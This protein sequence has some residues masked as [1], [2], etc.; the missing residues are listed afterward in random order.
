MPMHISRIQIL[1]VCKRQREGVEVFLVQQ[2]ELCAGRLLSQTSYLCERR[3]VDEK[4]YMRVKTL[5]VPSFPKTYT[6]PHADT[7][8]RTPRSNIPAYAIILFSMSTSTTR[9]ASGSVTP[10]AEPVGRAFNND[11][12]SVVSFRCRGPGVFVAEGTVAEVGVAAGR[13]TTT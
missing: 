1:R 5:T 9:A 7:T 2:R 10:F 11:D 6:D 8:S 13:T 3:L 4:A 12:A